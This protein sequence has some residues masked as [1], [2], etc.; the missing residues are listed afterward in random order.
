MSLAASRRSGITD[1]GVPRPPTMPRRPPCSAVSQ[2]PAKLSKGERR[3]CGCPTT[4]STTILRSQKTRKAG[5]FPTEGGSGDAAAELWELERTESPCA[6]CRRLRPD[7][8]AGQVLLLVP[9]RGHGS[10]GQGVGPATVTAPSPPPALLR[11]GGSG[12][13]LNVACS[14]TERLPHGSARVRSTSSTSE[15]RV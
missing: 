6:R 7:A 1:D 3:R 9:C 13:R 5:I 4:T 12:H 2:R 14:C 10:R 15:A 11:A 8:R